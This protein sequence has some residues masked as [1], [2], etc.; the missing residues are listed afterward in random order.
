MSDDP[1]KRLDS[2][3]TD[4]AASLR[5][6]RQRVIVAQGLLTLLVMTGFGWHGGAAQVLAAGYGGAVTILISGWLGWRLQRLNARTS[7]GSGLGLLYSSVVVRYV[8]AIVLLGLGLGVFRLSLLPLV[9]AFGLT[10][11]GFFAAARRH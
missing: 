1:Q 6:G 8:A 2:C 7:P 9:V 11:F 3:P 10:Q 4:P 5:Q